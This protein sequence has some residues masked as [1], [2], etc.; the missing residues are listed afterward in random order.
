VWRGEESTKAR[1]KPPETR[2]W[3]A[4]AGFAAGLLCASPARKLKNVITTFLKI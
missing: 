2:H 4:I 3:W 1:E